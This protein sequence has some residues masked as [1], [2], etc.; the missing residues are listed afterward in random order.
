[1]T[2]HYTLTKNQQ[3]I[4]QF[5][6]STFPKSW[7]PS[8]N[9]SPGQMLPIITQNEPHIIHLAQ[10]GFIPAHALDP[11]SGLKN[12]TAT[13]QDVSDYPPM[14]AAFKHRRCIIITDGYYEWKKIQGGHAPYRIEH[15]KKDILYVAG[16]YNFYTLQDGRE[17]LSFC[18]LLTKPNAKTSEFETPMPYIL[19]PHEIKKYL[20]H[21]PSTFVS[22]QASSL[23]VF[24]VDI[25]VNN[26]ENNNPN[27]IIPVDEPIPAKFNGKHKS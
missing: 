24:P 8:F 18:M 17:L 27:L 15:K 6:S 22:P 20:E 13:S 23:R 9:T 19:E 1:M 5:S 12:S 2:L 21:A 25:D 14:R 10:W 26:P 3:E 4:E 16:I 7:T 11:R